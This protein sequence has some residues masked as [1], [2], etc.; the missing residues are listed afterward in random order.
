MTIYKV[1]GSKSTN[2]LRL[3]HV[4]TGDSRAFST[5]L[6]LNPHRAHC[7]EFHP[8]DINERGVLT[9]LR[10]YSILSHLSLL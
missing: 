9:P 3:C 10:S 2:C 7:S 4:E 8:Q 5:I 1:V 6:V